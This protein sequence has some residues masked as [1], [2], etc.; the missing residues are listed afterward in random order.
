MMPKLLPGLIL[1]CA[2]APA[3]ASEMKE[4]IGSRGE[5]YYVDANSG[6][7]SGD[8]EAARINNTGTMLA[9]H[10]PQAPKAP[11]FPDMVPVSPAA[12][13]PRTK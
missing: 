4:C 13:A 2:A 7:S 9:P 12:P 8:R 11:T 3:A 5:S 10:V 1:L 6:C